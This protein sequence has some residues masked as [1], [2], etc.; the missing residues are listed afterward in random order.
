M[1]NDKVKKI[2]VIALM[3]SMLGLG[4]SGTITN[5]VNGTNGTSSVL[6]TLTFAL[7]NTSSDVTAYP[8]LKMDSI[9][10]ADVP[11]TSRTFIGIGNGQ[12]LLQNWT[13]LPINLT[14]I[15]A[16][17]VLVHIHAIKL[18]GIAHDDRLNYD[19]GVVNSTGG[20]FS[21]LAISDPTSTFITTT[22]QEFNIEG[23]MLERT[24]NM[25]DRI[26][27]RLYVNQTGSGAL[28]D[29]TIYMDDLTIS[30]LVIPAIPID[31]TGLINGVGNNT[32]NINLK[33][34]K[35]GDT[36]TGNLIMPR[37]FS[38]GISD[39]TVG[40]S[41][42]YSGGNG[43]YAGLLSY[44]TTYA[45]YMGIVENAYYNQTTGYWYRFNDLKSSVIIQILSRP[46]NDYGYQM[47]VVMPNSSATAHRIEYTEFIL[48][49]SIDSTGITYGNTLPITASYY[50]GTGT[51]YACFNSVGTIIRSDTVC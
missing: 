16:G 8:S 9:I 26:A 40:F 47:Y 4:V 24:I 27:L 6:G 29:I 20:N 45:S 10:V 50:A 38:I 5:G 34:N 35:S 36:M 51:D 13:S 11:K 1:D 31:L 22:E 25:T 15:P 43:Q 30:R 17:A 7:H 23:V 28:P 18:D 48:V 32:A 37:N 33:V 39:G 41:Q 3:L 42:N 49:T 12:T 44:D 21:S 2:A 14:L 19:I 46:A